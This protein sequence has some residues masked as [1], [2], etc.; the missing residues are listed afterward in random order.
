MSND[1]RALTDGAPEPTEREAALDEHI[2]D[3]TEIPAAEDYDFAAMVAGVKP[4]RARVRIRPRSDLYARLEEL[5]EEIDGFPTDED[6][7]EDLTA[8]WAETKADYDRT[9]VVVIEGRSSEWVK[10]FTKDA[11]ASGINP[12]RKGLSDEARFEHTKRL[13]FAQIAAQIVHPT[14]GVT[15]ESVGALFGANETEADK[16][17]RALQRVNSQPSGVA[18][19]FSRRR[20]EPS[21][22]G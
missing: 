6:V 10:S 5:A 1:E 12:D 22:S 11:K 18:P 19:D 2:D 21:Q 8:E 7:P 4:N 16:L 13:W 3:V 17:W 20:S 15:P 14:K 9:F